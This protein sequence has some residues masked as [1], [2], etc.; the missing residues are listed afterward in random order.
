MDMK[1]FTQENEVICS[2]SVMVPYGDFV[3]FEVEGLTFKLDFSESTEKTNPHVNYAIEEEENEHIMA[4]HAYNFNDALLSTLKQDLNLAKI[5]GRPLTLRL[6]ISACNKH[7][8]GDGEEKKI[9][10]DML[11]F[12]T[13][14]LKKK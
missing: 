10:S 6:S 12:Y 2:G 4:I 8:I 9:V 1:I 5:E 13:W 7:D 14:Y 3:K 11:V